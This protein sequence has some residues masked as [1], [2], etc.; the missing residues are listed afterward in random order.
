MFLLV[1]KHPPYFEAEY[2]LFCGRRRVAVARYR[3]ICLVLKV[4]F[5]NKFANRCNV[6]TIE[7]VIVYGHVPECHVTFGRGRL[8]NVWWDPHIDHKTSWG[9]I[10][11]VPWLHDRIYSLI[12][13]ILRVSYESTLTLQFTDVGSSTSG[14][15]FG[16]FLKQTIQSFQFVNLKIH[17]QRIAL[18]WK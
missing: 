18:F 14:Y 17:V 15:Y 9:T 8:H 12:L 3:M 11:N 13:K 2:C 4:Q 16:H 6:C 1:L 7:G 10:S 5:G